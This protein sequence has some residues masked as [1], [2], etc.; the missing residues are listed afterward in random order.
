M[1]CSNC[2]TTLPRVARFCLTCGAPQT[3]RDASPGATD[4][5]ALPGSGVAYDGWIC[6]TGL[7]R[8]YVKAQ[9]VA[10]VRDGDQLYEAA[11]S[12]SF[13][14]GRGGPSEDDPRAV[15]AF[16]TL[17]EL[18]R[19]HGW[20]PVAGGQPWY[21]Y[22]FRWRLHDV[23]GLPEAAPPVAPRSRAPHTPEAGG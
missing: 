10:T 17:I 6:E 16:E 22:R 7:W 1:R 19:N 5:A 3:P 12:P 20:E 11:R 4:G 14:C 2:G 18:L 21:A 8:G 15:R 23:G 13:R 9:F